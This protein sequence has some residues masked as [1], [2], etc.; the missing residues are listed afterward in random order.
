VD[1]ER[2]VVLVARKRDADESAL[3]L[4]FARG[5]EKLSSRPK[6]ANAEVHERSNQSHG[7]TLTEPRN[8]HA[9]AR[10]G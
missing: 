7:G 1:A 6:L 8:P 5:A 4:E 10:A 9:I 3:T 2:E